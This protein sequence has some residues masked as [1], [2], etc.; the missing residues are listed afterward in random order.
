MLLDE[1]TS[2]LDNAS[3]K[4]VQAALDD[5]LK[6]NKFTSIT[7]AHRLST[8]MHSDK[9]A[10]VKKGRIVEQGTYSELLAIGQDGEFYQLAAKQEAHREQDRQSMREDSLTNSS[11]VQSSHEDKPETARSE[12]EEKA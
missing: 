5:I 12:T 11:A 4:V 3:E 10:V 1:A 2:A 8:I 6:A 7:I 9:I